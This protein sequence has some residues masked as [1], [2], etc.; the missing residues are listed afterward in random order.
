MPSS[1]TSSPLSGQLVTIFGGT[2]Y[3]G[4]YVAQSLLA[5]G[6]RLRLASRAPG[7]AQSLKPL[8]NLGQ[9]QLMPCDITR[10]EHVAAALEGAS[11]VVNLVGA[12]SGDLGKLMGEAPGTIARLAAERGIRALVHVSAIG[13]DAASRTAYARGKA[14][15]EAN[16]AAAF[17]GATILRPSIVF[18]KDDNFINL[19]A[20]MIELLPVLPVFGPEAKLQLVYADDVAEA[21]AVALEH[22]E[23]HGGRT[24]ELGGPEQLS[25]MEIHRRIAAAQGRKRTFLAVP[26]GLSATFAALPVTPMTRDQWTLLKPGSTVAPGALGLVDLGIEARPLG[27]FLDKWMLRYRKHGRFGAA[28]ERAKAYKA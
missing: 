1:P 5:R 19:F 25:M 21:V 4:N 14:A 9:L 24:Y 6:A 27:L 7:K 3:I 13:A 15:G 26:D 2:G 17:P 18:G 23:Q 16:V 12:F 28:N 20:G 8:A 11:Y 10:E 22:P